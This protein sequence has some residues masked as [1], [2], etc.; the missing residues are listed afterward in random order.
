MSAPPATTDGLGVRLLARLSGFIAF[1]RRRGLPIGLGGEVDLGRA[2]AELGLL[3]KEAFREACRSTLAKSRTDLVLLDAAFDAY[4]R[5]ARG[6][7]EAEDGPPDAPAPKNPPPADGLP[8][9]RATSVALG[10]G[11]DSSRPVPV[12][13]FSPE[14]PPPGHPLALLPARELLGIRMGARRFRR[15]IATLPGRRFERS[16]RGRID[17]P[18]T[19]RGSLRHGGEWVVF[20]RRRKRL[21]RTDLLLLWDVSGSMKEHD[22]GLFALVYALHRTSPRSRVFA[23][24]T[25]L[26]EITERFRGRAYPRTALAVLPVL[27]AAEGGTRIGTC[28]SDFRRRFGPLVRPETTVV[29]L[30]DG[31]DLGE[32]PLLGEEL[33]RLRRRAHLVAWISP[34]AARPGFEPL[35]SGLKEA[36][37][38]VDLLLAP[39]HFTSRGALRSHG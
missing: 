4:W 5:G 24:S 37:P 32:G 10:R 14:A 34:Y 19:A 7:E 8:S 21:L 39:E 22:S 20:R 33:E 1:L 15:R 26:H 9:G 25:G 11:Y 23:F 2:L 12:G 30:S 16:G 31:W 28:L 17:F 29:I 36:L 38:H 13:L 35:T 3:D 18:A 6:T 27:D